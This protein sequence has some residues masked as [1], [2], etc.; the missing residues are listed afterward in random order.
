MVY[1][2]EEINELQKQ[3]LL[4]CKFFLY[5]GIITFETKEENLTKV[6]SFNSDSTFY[7]LRKGESEIL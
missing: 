1:L 2:K 3:F 6:L 4:L 7:F 5:S